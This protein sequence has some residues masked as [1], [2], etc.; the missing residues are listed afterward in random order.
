[1]KKVLDL[2]HNIFACHDVKVEEKRA[3]Q[4]IAEE[5]EDSYDWWFWY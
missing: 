5:E 3:I 4:K 1:M 2:F